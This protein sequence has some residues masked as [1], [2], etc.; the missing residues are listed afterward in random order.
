MKL[1][2]HLRP[3]AGPVDIGAFLSVFFV[4]LAFILFRTA[5][6]P[7]QGV[8]IELPQVSLAR[9]PGVM[10]PWITVVVDQD[11]RFYFDGQLIPAD[12]LQTQLMEKVRQSPEPMTLLIE[13]DRRVSHEQ[14]LRLCSLAYKAGIR[15]IVL[16]TRPSPIPIRSHPR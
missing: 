5:L 6:I 7:P 4:L 12:A 8:E 1:P 2:R 9:L 16:A 10:R 3:L 15:R 11:G 14:V 13:A